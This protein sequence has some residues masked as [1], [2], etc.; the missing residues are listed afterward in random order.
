MPEK[1][2]IA[3]LFSYSTLIIITILLVTI[4]AAFIASQVLNFS[5]EMEK[6]EQEYMEEQQLRYQ[7]RVEELVEYIDYNRSRT[8]SIL[9]ENARDKVYQA[10]SIARH[11]YD[12]NKNNI[13]LNQIQHMV[14]ETLRP[15]RFYDERGYYFI[16]DLE[17]N[18]V[19]HPGKRD[20][21]GA[22]GYNQ[23]DIR[24]KYII[25]EFIAIAKNKGEGKASYYWY[26]LA[27]EEKEPAKKIAYVK[28]F[29]PFN[30]VIGTGEY[31]EDVE[32]QVREE[33]ILRVNN[34]RFGRH[35]KNY[36]FV[37]QVTDIENKE[38]FGYQLINPARPEL[39][40]QA[41]S[42]N[43]RDEK[44]N[45]VFKPLFKK[46][47]TDG[48]G[49]TKYW[50]LN[51]GSGAI[52]LK[53]TYFKW[54]KP[55]DWIIGAG[56]YHDDL[57]ALIARREKNLA[58][59]LKQDVYLIFGIFVVFSLLALLASRTLARRIGKEFNVF[60]EFLKQSVV[61]NQ[62]LDRSRL[63]VTEFQELADA[64]DSMIEA[65]IAGEKAIIRAKEA[66]EAATQ[67]KSEF[68]AN[69]SHEIRTPMNA[70]IGMS[71]ILA[72]TELTDEQFEYLEIIN[73][74][75]NNLL[76][77][78][79][80]ILDFS[81]IEA[82]RL[83][84]DRLNFNVRDVIEGVADMIAP[85][86]HKKHLELVTLIEPDVPA[87][88][89]GDSSRLHQIL[90]N[91]TNNAVKFT[92]KGEIVVSARVKE[93]RKKQGENKNEFVLV[94]QVKDT[95]IGISRED[96]KQLFKTFSQ[97]DATTTRKYGGTG[98]GLAISRKLAQLMGGDI[99]V[100]S[101][102]GQGSAF[103]FTCVLEEV[104]EEGQTPMWSPDFRRLKVLIVDDNS[105]NR[106]ILSKYLQVRECICEEA[107]S[108][109][110]AMGKLIA[111]ANNNEP[112]DLGLLDFQMPEVS[113]AELAEMIKSNKALKNMPL[114]LLSSSTAYKT[115]E[116]LRESGFSALLYKPVKQSQL[117][118][119]IAGVMGEDKVEEPVNRVTAVDPE[120]LQ[121]ALE[122][123][124][125]ILLVEDNVFNQK[126][127]IFNLRKFK[128][129]VDLVENGRAAIEKFQ[130]NPY[131][132]IL[133][134]IQMPVMDGYEATEAIRRI[135]MEESEKTGEEIHTPIIAMTA[136]AMMED[137]QKSYDAGMDAHLAKPFNAEKFIKVIHDIAY[138]E[139][140]F[141]K[142]NGSVKPNH[143]TG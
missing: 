78:I 95:G 96:Q 134:D 108:A 90:L 70:I 21:E 46:I 19:L 1:K 127:A 27:N 105:T 60:S 72:Q 102:K 58:R 99:G 3:R 69:M 51:P 86:A 63:T 75:G 57:K 98:L 126:V 22:F 24:G 47:E 54:Y 94:F 74:S 36:F 16:A 130:E 92:D 40:G 122:N 39:V 35:R 123:P 133:M 28:L 125:N 76:V 6:V 37:I 137:V 53:T 62:P 18:I 124:L 129:N 73:T 44:G 84:I 115:H 66:A 119:G 80:D 48:E 136:N 20:Q 8:E 45:P 81:K 41:M 7:E 101:Q 26:K 106:F 49:V 131:D 110:E 42:F 109:R 118:R 11:I 5:N 34:M 82:G 111:A 71:D 87:Q 93:I 139:I 68:L 113:G 30:W 135:E 83:N 50:Y 2:S 103:W 142:T 29:E 138:G 88:L 112:F 14:K 116:E 12:I 85:K 61:K 140:I 4:M 97:L 132:I 120:R 10:I 25:R 65:K 13:S 79:N 38:S 141:S 33:M 59:R 89:L 91:L 121:H 128:H 55:W 52:S 107:E 15:I 17:G 100:D 77:I 56:F 9:V 23:R 117:F 143:E 32:N 31:I 114:I 64:A 67:A 104:R 43:H